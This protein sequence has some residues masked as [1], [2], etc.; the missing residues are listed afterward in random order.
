MPVPIRSYVQQTQ[1]PTG[2]GPALARAPTVSDGG[3]GN[4]LSG[5]GNSF[6][7]SADNLIEVREE[8][9]KAWAASAIADARLQ[10]TDS[11]TTRQQQA[12]PGAPGFTP[13]FLTDFD[14][15]T[16]D[17]VKNA[18]TESARKFA[19]QRLLAL[20]DD[21]GGR[22]IAFE[23]QARIDNRQDQLNNGIDNTRKLM[24]SD[25]DQYM[26]ALAEQLA[27]IRSTN[28]PPVNKSAMEKKAIEKVSE[29]AVWSQMQKSPESFLASIG[30]DAVDPKTGK[31]RKIN[32][33]M[34][35]V[36]GNPAFDALPFDQ[37]NRM[38][39]QAIKLKSQR[40]ADYERAT[41]TERKRIADEHM[42]EGWNRLFSGKLDRNYIEQIR[43][44]ID[45]N[46]YKSLLVGLKE[47][48]SGGGG[49]KSDPGVY[50]DLQKMID[51]DPSAARDFALRMH[52]NGRLSN[53]HLSQALTLVRSSDRRE[54]PKTPYERNR[55]WLTDAMDPGP[56]VQDPIGRTRMADA[57]Y[58]Y[59]N[60]AKTGNRTEEDLEK[61][62]R[63]VASRY[64]L[65]D[66]STS[67][68]TLPMPRAG[69][70]PRSG[71]P[72]TVQQKVG[73]LTRQVMKNKAD[74]KIDEQTYLDE[75]KILKRW[76]DATLIGK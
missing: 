39:E 48:Q 54:G 76:H 67:L 30:F 23:A 38:L 25:P 71:D 18:P 62:S 33:D 24:N 40:D 3:I 41:T 72:A 44:H 68:L 15:Y 22:A 34:A 4:A 52:Q 50:R 12:G 37:R 26:E 58:D 1:T 31:A 65:V 57:V 51:S 59:D 7:K 6:Y 47:S 2:P 75:M 64:K 49:A 14:K 70:L 17:T 11:L 21:F 61:Y 8:E 42:K 20:R 13:Q 55:R 73:V 66:F 36:T 28:L 29:A 35:A 27:I 60:Y 32:G 46:E 63:S 69:S 56:M 16:E 74:G 5:L 9:G 45:D 19:R 10:W 53:E 43:P